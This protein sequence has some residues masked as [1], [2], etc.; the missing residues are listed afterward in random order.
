MHCNKEK[1][2]RK[3]LIHVVFYD[4]LILSMTTHNDHD[5]RTASAA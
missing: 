2:N 3:N 5:D 1:M 4:S